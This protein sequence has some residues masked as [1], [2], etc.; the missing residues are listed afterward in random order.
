M[1]TNYLA[2]ND[3]EVSDTGDNYVCVAK[4]MAFNG[5]DMETFELFLQGNIT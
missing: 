1:V 2:I 5:M 3:T 4:N